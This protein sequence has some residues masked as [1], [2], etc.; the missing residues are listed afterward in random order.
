MMMRQLVGPFYAMAPGVVL[1]LM[2]GRIAQR[3]FFDAGLID[4]AAP[5]PGSA[6]DIDNRVLKNTVEQSVLALC[7]WPAISVMLFTDGPGV[8][9]A[10]SVGFAVAR[11]AFWWGYHKSPPLRA[12]GFAATFYPTVLALLWALVLRLF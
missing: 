12:F 7:L 1:M 6:A 3:R 4:G 9:L 8:V 2:I 5:A 11:L 10:L